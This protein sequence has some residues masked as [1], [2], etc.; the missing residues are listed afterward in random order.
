VKPGEQ[1]LQRGPKEEQRKRKRR[2]RKTQKQ[3]KNGAR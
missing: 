3:K 2:K 1:E